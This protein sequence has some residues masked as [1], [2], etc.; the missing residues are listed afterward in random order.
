MSPES[1][2]AKGYCKEWRGSDVTIWSVKIVVTNLKFIHNNTFGLVMLKGWNRELKLSAR[3][4]A[5]RMSSFSDVRLL[6]FEALGGISALA[7]CARFGKGLDVTRNIYT[8]LW[9]RPVART[10]SGPRLLSLLDSLVCMVTLQSQYNYVII[11]IA[12]S[13]ARYPGVTRLFPSLAE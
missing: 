9:E 11:P 2:Q 4:T 10:K 3:I 5:C 6:S 1:N 8:V 12:F 7:R 13:V